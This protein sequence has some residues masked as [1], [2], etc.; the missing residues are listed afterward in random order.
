[1]EAKDTVKYDCI[2]GSYDFEPFYSDLSKETI[3]CYECDAYNT[4]KQ[5]QA[6]ITWPV[7]Y[8]A[9]RNSVMAE[10]ARCFLAT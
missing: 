6:E 9:G 5:A 4:G 8:E 10:L 1:M 2:C 7:A 3:H